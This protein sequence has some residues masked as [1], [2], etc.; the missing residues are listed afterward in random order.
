[1]CRNELDM[2]ACLSANENQKNTIMST[3]LMTQRSISILFPHFILLT[4]SFSFGEQKETLM[5]SN[6]VQ[7]NELS[8]FITD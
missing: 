8:A 3:F 1:M 2:K 7:S 6:C 4:R 5:D